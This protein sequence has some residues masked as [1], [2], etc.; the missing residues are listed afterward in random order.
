MAA[1][2]TDDA[3]AADIICSLR[4][5]DLAGWTP[6]WR[7]RAKETDAAPAAPAELSWPALARGK[8]SRRRSP[9]AS[10]SASAAKS[11]RFSARSS[12]ASPLDYSAGSVRS[13]A[14][15][16][17][18]EDGAFCSPWHRRALVTAPTTTA[19]TTKPG[20]EKAMGAISSDFLIA[21]KISSHFSRRKKVSSH[22]ISFLPS[23]MILRPVIRL[24]VQVDCG[25]FVGYALLLIDW[26]SYL[27]TKHNCVSLLQVGSIGR[28][29]LTFQAPPP[30][31]A[32]QRQRKKMR[33]PEVQQ[34]VRSL[35]VENE[36]LHEEMRALQRACSALSKENDKLETRIEQSNSQK[37]IALKE[38][39]GKQPLDQQPPHDS[40]AL[41]DLNLP[42]Q[43]NADSSSVHC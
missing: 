23:V 3:V 28:P 17:G 24:G 39:K 40:F 30:R 13:G 42:A 22:S 35:A 1:A 21:Q 34:L 25:L 20:T 31:P 8:R 19:T 4:G 15:T 18:G 12:P 27:L 37:E 32:G 38:Q 7:N 41:P 9:S 6:P 11:T 26:S 2:G 14:S 33:L 36:S 29:Q 43:D 10:A 5:A 16:S